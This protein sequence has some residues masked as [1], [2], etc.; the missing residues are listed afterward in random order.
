MRHTYHYQGN[1]PSTGQIL[2]LE[3]TPEAEAAARQLMDELPRDLAEGKMFGLLITAEG[4]FLRAFSGCWQGQV[5][6]L[7][8]VPPIL[9][10]SPSPVPAEL[11]SLN[12]QIK[13]L[14]GQDCFVRVSQLQE[15]WKQRIQEVQ[16]LHKEAKRQRDQRRQQGE[17]PLEL[18]RESQREGMLLRRLR[19]QRQAELQSPERAAAEAQAQI[20]QRKRRRRE[21]SAQLQAEMHQQL[22]LCLSAGQPWSLAS[23]FPSGPPTGTGE[24][25]APKLLHRAA[26]LGLTPVAMAEFWWGPA[27]AGRQSGEFYA[28]CQERCQPLIGPLLAR[29]RPLEILYQDDQLLAVHKPPGV[30]CQ[31]GRQNWNQ[32][33]LWGRLLPRFPELLPV[34]RLD[35]ETS[36]VL[37]WAR[38]PRSQRH[39]QAQFAERAL[40]KTYEALLCRAPARREGR[41]ELALAADPERPGCYRPDPDGKA[42]LT[43]FRQLDGCRTELRPHTGRSHQLRV[44]AA[45]GLHS[46][47][48]GD[49]LYG[50]GPGPL[51]LHARRL[52]FTHPG[53][54]Q[55]VLEA[56]P[57][58]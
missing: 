26:A 6:L 12:A 5:E 21:L 22:S 31:P 42:C 2:R 9:T 44:H 47:I 4:P 19:S 45:Y 38:N 11:Q 15:H 41:I 28:A 3:R 17:S 7:G 29:A 25:C 55:L 40:E 16:Q 37:L 51:R 20:L 24:C 23:L 32:D 8:W 13:Q 54:G 43:D 39:L 33:S 27:A 58:F 35:L 10:H 30:L 34:H 14:A 46:P 49:S 50:G 1:C 18:Q 36:G 52:Q 48:A 53:G 56:S 57:P